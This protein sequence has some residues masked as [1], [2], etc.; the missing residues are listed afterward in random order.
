MD[1]DAHSDRPHFTDEG[2][3]RERVERRS[4]NLT[5]VLLAKAALDCVLVVWLAADFAGAAFAPVE[6]G[7]IELFDGGLRGR[8]VASDPRRDTD[9]QLFVDGVFVTAARARCEAESREPVARL[10]SICEYGFALP[11][12]AAGEHEAS[13]YIAGEDLGGGLRALLI[14]GKPLRF[15]IKDS[16]TNRTDA[17]CERDR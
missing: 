10:V 8:F 14:V 1:E 15:T 6:A 12:L 17:T 2:R 9:V 3:E 13:L 7:Q 11:P 4:R 16:E 5:R